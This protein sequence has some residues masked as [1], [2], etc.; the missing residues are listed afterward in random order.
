MPIPAGLTAHLVV[1]QPHFPVGRLK[2]TLDRLS[3]ADPPYDLRRGHA[4]AGEDYIRWQF[5]RV[6]DRSAYEEPSPPDRALKSSPLCGA[7]KKAK[8]RR[9]F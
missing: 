4:L 6:A 9:A 2:A 1:I 8:V 3:G 7:D 5:L